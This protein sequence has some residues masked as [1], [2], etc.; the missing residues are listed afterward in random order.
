MQ[1][2]LL[3]ELQRIFTP[4]RKKERLCPASNIFVMFIHKKK[5]VLK[6]IR[7]LCEFIDINYSVSLARIGV[8][9]SDTNLLEGHVI[10]P[11]NLHLMVS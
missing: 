6:K 8:A 10:F 9:F 2:L 7:F 5:P 4:A 11:E 3:F 1:T